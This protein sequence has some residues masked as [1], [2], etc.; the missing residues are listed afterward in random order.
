MMPN[1]VALTIGQLQRNVDGNQVEIKV[2]MEK[3]NGQ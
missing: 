2:S 3:L 1:L